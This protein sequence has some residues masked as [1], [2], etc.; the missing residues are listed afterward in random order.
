[1][2]LVVD[3]VGLN[4]SGPFADAD[5]LHRGD[6][7]ATRKEIEAAGF[8]FAAESKLYARPDDPKTALVFN[9]AIRGKTDQFIYTFVKPKR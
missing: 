6:P 4:A 3:H 9:P 2:L 7:A 5:S 1:M 8:R